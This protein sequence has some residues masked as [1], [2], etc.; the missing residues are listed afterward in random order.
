MA[1]HGLHLEAR[2]SIVRLRRQSKGHLRGGQQHV[3]QLVQPGVGVQAQAGGRHAQ[4]VARG[5]GV[6]PEPGNRLIQRL[7]RR[8]QRI[9]PTGAPFRHADVRQ[10]VAKQRA[11]LA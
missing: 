4:V 1:H 9:L 10:R 2:R 6:L 11:Q 5:H 8:Q 7:R 3:D